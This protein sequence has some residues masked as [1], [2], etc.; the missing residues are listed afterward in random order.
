MYNIKINHSNLPVIID[1]GST[2]NILDEKLYINI[3]PSLPLATSTTKIFAYGSKQPLPLLGTFKATVT[4]NRQ[5]TTAK[6]HVTKGSSGTLL[7]KKT[8][9]YLDLL[10]VG[11]VETAFSIQ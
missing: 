5:Q 7:G 2:L 6:F 3:K 4:A 8:A 11:Q 1:S 9:E 10:R